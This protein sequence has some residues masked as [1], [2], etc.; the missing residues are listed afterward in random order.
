MKK[1][2]WVTKQQQQ[3]KTK[4]LNAEFGPPRAARTAST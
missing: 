2:T 1:L 3:T 4:C